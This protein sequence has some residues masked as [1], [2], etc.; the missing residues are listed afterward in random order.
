MSLRTED[1]LCRCGEEREEERHLADSCPLYKDIRERFSSLEED[2]QLGEFFR[3]ILE[4][5]DK[6]DE[7]EQERSEQ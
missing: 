7:Q 5:R 2:D 6:I 4:R 3:Q 1:S